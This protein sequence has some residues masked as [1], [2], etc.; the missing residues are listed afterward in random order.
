MNAH[1][2]IILVSIAFIPSVSSAQVF[3]SAFGFISDISDNW[4]IVTREVVSQN[5]EMLNFDT[6]EIKKINTS[7]K[8][9]IKKMALAGKME[10]LYYK[11]SDVDFLDNINIIIGQKKVSNLLQRTKELCMVLPAQIKQ[12]WKRND[13]S[14]VRYCKYAKVY[15]VNTISYAFDG[16]NYGTTSYGY[17]FNTKKNTITLTIT[18]KNNKCKKVKSDAELIFQDMKI[19]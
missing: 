8:S 18:C 14:D 13:Y 19:K 2:K 12:A 6:N 9:Q 1:I 15:G 11:D 5:P 10:A 7:L 4:L 3:S 17:Y 16:L